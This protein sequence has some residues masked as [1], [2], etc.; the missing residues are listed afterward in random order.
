MILPAA[1]YRKSNV[2]VGINGHKWTKA[3][4]SNGLLGEED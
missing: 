2:F 3:G 4:H 1:V